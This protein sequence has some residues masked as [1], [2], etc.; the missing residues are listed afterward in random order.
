VTTAVER[1]EGWLDGPRGGRGRGDVLRSAAQVGTPVDAVHAAI[2]TGESVLGTKDRDV[3]RALAVFPPTPN[4]FSRGAALAVAQPADP[5]ALDRLADAWLIE[6]VGGTDRYT[7]HQTIREYAAGEARSGRA[8]QDAGRR[9][10]RFVAADLTGRE[11]TYDRCAAEGGN[12]LEAVRVGLELGLPGEVVRCVNAFYPY[13]EASGTYGAADVRTLLDTAAEAGRDL[14]AKADAARAMLNLARVLE[15]E[16]DYAGA[17][18]WLRDSLAAAEAADPPDPGLISDVHL[19][20]GVLHFTCCRYAD[21]AARLREALDA[22][23]P[24]DPRRRSCARRWL[25][26]VDVA[27]GGPSSAADHL[28]AG[29]ADLAALR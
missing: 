16:S 28:R 18:Q 8:W 13:V 17:G 11:P 14:P 25:V 19:A 2:R 24:D 22:A 12:I 26:A 21:A 5:E 20:W 27:R 6:R 9:L 4:T 7:I 15:K 29:W 10:V 23:G 1:L 3:L